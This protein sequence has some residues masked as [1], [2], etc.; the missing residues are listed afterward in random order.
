MRFTYAIKFVDDMDRA[1]AFYRDHIGLSLKFATPEWT[2]F[3]SGETTLALHPADPDHPAGS[4]QLGFGSDDIDAF[5]TAA[6]AAGVV[7]TRPIE[8]VHGMRI[9]RVRDADGAEV[10]CS[11]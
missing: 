6:T 5:H 9:A 11:G 8:T 10:S 3:A 7:F 2:E 4:V 1:V